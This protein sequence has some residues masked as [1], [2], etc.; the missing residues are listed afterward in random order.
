MRKNKMKELSIDLETYSDVDIKQC[1]V[2]KYTDTPNFDILLFSYSI[3]GGDVITVDLASG[4]EIPIAVIN[5]LTNDTVIK[6]AFNAN[7]ERV[8]LSVWLRKYYP[9]YFKG[10]Y[11]GDTLVNHYL[12]PASWHCSKVWANYMGLPHSLKAVGK[13][14]NLTHQKMQQGKE[15][16]RYFCSPC[17]PTKKNGMRTRNLPEH[18]PS[19][20]E[21]FKQYN[22]RD[23]EV[24]LAIKEKLKLN[25]HITI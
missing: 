4:E 7:F 20:W 6:W 8:C 18:N 9:Q 10:Y 22:K 12:N 13:E 15:L 3:D 2:Y 5:A 11:A 14:L 23:V 16:I 21:I 25:H 24:E 19:D 17:N 1:G